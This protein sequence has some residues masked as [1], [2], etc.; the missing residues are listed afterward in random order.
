MEFQYS[1]YS[2]IWLVGAEIE[3][4]FI[5]SDLVTFDVMNP[6]IMTHDDFEIVPELDSLLFA[7]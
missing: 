4:Y 7:E 1:S 6:K 3:I 2:L 5:E